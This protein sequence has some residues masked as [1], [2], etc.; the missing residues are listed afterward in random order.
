MRPIAAIRRTRNRRLEVV[1]GVG[2]VA[3]WEGARWGRWWQLYGGRDG[4]LVRPVEDCLSSIMSR[5]HSI[6]IGYTHAVWTRHVVAR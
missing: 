3:W 5:R 2:I 4:S 6:L 1:P